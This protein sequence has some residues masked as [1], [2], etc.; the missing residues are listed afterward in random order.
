MKTQ[1]E[2]NHLLVKEKGLEQTLPSQPSE[3]TNPARHPD[4]ALLISSAAKQFLLFEPSS[5]WYFVTAILGKE[6]IHM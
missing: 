6:C 4:L 2:D 1:R 5:W 3:R